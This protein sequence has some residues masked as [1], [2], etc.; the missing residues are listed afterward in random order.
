[1]VG[2]LVLLWLAAIAGV[3]YPYIWGSRRWQFAIAAALIG[4]TI[5]AVA[6]KD[7]KSSETAIETA[8]PRTMPAKPF[9]SI[10]PKAL[11]AHRVQLTIGTNLPMPIKVATSIDL[12]GQ[13]PT[14][15]YIGYS[16]FIT[17]TGASTTVVLDTSKSDKPL[18]AG[19]YDAT[20]DFFPKWGAEGNE[21]AK[22]APQLHAEKQLKL[23]GSSGSA[24]DA[25]Q[26]NEH[27]SWV[28]ENVA[29]NMPWS[30]ASFERRLGKSDKGRSDLS[31][32]HDAYYFPGADMTLLVN[33]LQ[34]QVTTWKMGNA[35]LA[36]NATKAEF[37]KRGLKWPL[38]A[39]AGYLGCDGNAVWFATAD[40]TTYA[41]NG[42]AHGRYKP[43][44]P[45][46]S[47]DQ[48]MMR[49]LKAA[50]AGGGSPARIN[51][52]DLIQEGLKLCS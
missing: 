4:I 1:M 30:K 31:H 9:L 15:T 22:G 51:I 17:L 6:P 48:K 33:R 2:I 25:R 34:N 39:E 35:I 40:G 13:K 42:A 41:V 18:P 29:M 43:I 50:G 37:E 14:D 28:M 52:G 19:D 27:Q 21:L 11:D 24:A 10:E 3:A 7:G 32:L 8:S 45:I 36:P 38:S 16:E 47:I 5:G 46:W 23:A 26:L 20:V 12:R 44:E 49:E